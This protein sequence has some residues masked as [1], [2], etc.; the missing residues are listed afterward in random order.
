MKTEARRLRE[1]DFADVTAIPHTLFSPVASP[2]V[3]G[4]QPLSVHVVGNGRCR[5]GVDQ[6]ASEGIDGDERD[7]DRECGGGKKAFLKAH[8]S[9]SRSAA[10]GVTGLP[11]GFSLFNRQSLTSG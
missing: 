1:E 9:S 5:P 8:R 6:M 7:Q 4:R 11:E 3:D 10:A 2:S